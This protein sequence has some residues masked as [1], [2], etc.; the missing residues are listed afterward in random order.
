MANAEKTAPCAVQQGDKAPL[1][2]S[3]EL[4]RDTRVVYIEHR[5][6]RYALQLTRQDKLILTK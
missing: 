5:G 2:H 1:L 4:F 3:S 6:E